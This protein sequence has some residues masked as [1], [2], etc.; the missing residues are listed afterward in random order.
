MKKTR[1]IS[2][3]RFREISQ[4]FNPNTVK[5]IAFDF[6]EFWSLIKVNNIP[7]YSIM[8]GD[9]DPYYSKEG[10][11]ILDEIISNIDP[12]IKIVINELYRGC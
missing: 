8:F 10:R 4:T 11:R 7:T 6:D 1:R 12:S 5:E 2:C 3:K 9:A